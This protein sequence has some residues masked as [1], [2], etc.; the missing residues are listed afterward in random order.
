[1]SVSV[2]LLMAAA[3]ASGVSDTY[4]IGTADDS[5]NLYATCVDSD[6][7]YIWWG[8]YADQFSGSPYGWM[9][10]LNLDGTVN[11]SKEIDKPNSQI[12]DGVITATNNGMVTVGNG[13]LNSTYSGNRAYLDW[14]NNGLFNAKKRNLTTN[15]EIATGIGY[16]GSGNVFYTIGQGNYSGS[17][18]V[19]FG[20]VTASGSDFSENESRRFQYFSSFPSGFEPPTYGG[21]AVDS[22]GKPII[23]GY[24]LNCAR[25]DT[26]LSH[27]VGKTVSLYTTEY[28]SPSLAVDSNDNVILSGF[29]R[30]NSSSYQEALLI[31]LNQSDFS[32]AWARAIRQGTSNQAGRSYSCCVDSNDNVYMCGSLQ[33]GFDGYGFI[34]KY[35][36]S[37]TLQWTR[38]FYVSGS[39]PTFVLNKIKT[40]PR[41][42]VLVAGYINNG[43]DKRALILKIPSDG[44]DAQSITI[45]SRTITISNPSLTN[46]NWSPSTSNYSPN[47]TDTSTTN[48]GNWNHTVPNSGYTNTIQ[49][50]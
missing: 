28:N 43:S 24:Y 34:A 16:Q 6:G 46:T 21:I 25:Y 2:K 33:V 11:A 17:G 41:D 37:G 12:V 15:T 31:K 38:R 22:S 10:V 45:D 50:L 19:T 1:M 39:Y 42:N 48:M 23:A 49:E 4:F 3:G 30:A 14:S 8:G 40:D 32:V 44:V 20:K 27:D 36:S 13:Y 47:L 29:G 18:Y 7:E 9:T 5:R 35:N 26:S